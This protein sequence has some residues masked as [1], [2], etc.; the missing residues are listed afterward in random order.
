MGR[1]FLFALLATCA[2]APAYAQRAD[3]NATTAAEDGFGKSV[4]NE[5][6]GVYANGQVRGFSAYDA[7][8]ARIEGLYYNESGSI[9]DLLQSGSDIRVGLTAFGQPFPA[10]T[11]IVDT[12]L[13]RVTSKRT[14]VSARLDSGEYLGPSGTLKAAIP[15]S[16]NLGVNAALPDK[17]R[18]KGDHVFALESRKDGTFFKHYEDFSGS[19]A[20]TILAKHGEVIES[21]FEIFNRALKGKAEEYRPATIAVQNGSAKGRRSSSCVHALRGWVCKYQNASA[22]ACGSSEPSSPL[23]SR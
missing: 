17:S 11:G 23:V 16:E 18:F 6:V 7:G 3:E 10:P 15:V 19:D 1:G 20:P 9:T 21:N 14:I 13:R 12:E 5:S 8:N 2:F 4:G 22:I